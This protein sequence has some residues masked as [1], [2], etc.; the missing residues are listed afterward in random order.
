L[1]ADRAEEEKKE[2]RNV[3]VELLCDEKMWVKNV[4]EVVVVHQTVVDIPW[5]FALSR[6]PTKLFALLVTALF[7]AISDPAPA[8][9]CNIA[10]SFPHTLIGR[11]LITTSAQNRFASPS[12]SFIFPLQCSPHR[13]ILGLPADVFQKRF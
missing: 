6:T 3:L 1:T 12:P 13:L 5:Q 4:A 8:N 2:E 10:F 7:T 11:T 9:P